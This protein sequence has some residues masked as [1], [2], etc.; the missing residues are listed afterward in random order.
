MRMPFNSVKSLNFHSYRSSY[1]SNM[2]HT[3]EQ[4]ASV[5]DSYE[6]YLV[7]KANEKKLY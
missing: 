5:R 3:V 4:N 6:H 1:N 2:T 7:Q